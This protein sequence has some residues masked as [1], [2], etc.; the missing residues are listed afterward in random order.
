[1]EQNTSNWPE[2]K[3]LYVLIDILK[4]NLNIVKRGTFSDLKSTYYV[5]AK[6][7]GF[8]LCSLDILLYR[9]ISKQKSLIS[10]IFI[11]TQ[12]LL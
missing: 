9:Y 8:S 12:P 3:G 10:I 1:M 7:Q 2:K 5:L 6:A 11:K 4:S